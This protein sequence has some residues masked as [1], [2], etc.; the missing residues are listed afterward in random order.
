L[1]FG[2]TD[3]PFWMNFKLSINL[4]DSRDQLKWSH[5]SNKMEIYSSFN[6]EQVA[7]TG[8][9]LAIIFSEFWWILPFFKPLHNQFPSCMNQQAS[10]SWSIISLITLFLSFWFILIHFSLLIFFSLIS[11]DFERF[12]PVE[13]FFDS[14]LG[15]IVW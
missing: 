3:S 13:V 6:V 9:S 14:L 1:R 5:S 10:A 12:L 7:V 2:N 8:L 15:H 4:Y 11:H